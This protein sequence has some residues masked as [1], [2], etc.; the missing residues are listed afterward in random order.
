MSAEKK[1]T[2]STEVLIV[3]DST[4]QA[5]QLSHVLVQGGYNV[6]IAGNGAEALQA[7][8]ETRPD[9]IISDAV[10]PVMDGYTMCRII[11][12]DVHLREIP[13]ILLTSLSDPRDVINGIEAGVDHYLTKPYQADALLSKIEAVLS[14][15]PSREPDDTEGQFSVTVAGD[16]R[17][18]RSSKQRLLTLLLSTYESA[19]LRNKELI[20]A[21]AELE[22]ANKELEA[23]AYAVSHDLRAPLR[24][25]SGFSHALL[26]DYG[27]DLKGEARE[28]LDQITQ[29]S[30][31]MGELID[32]ILRLS[33]STRGEL[34]REEVNLSSLAERILGDMIKAEPDRRVAWKV[35]PNLTARC[36]VKL[37]EVVLTNLLGN[38]WKYT[39]HTSEP[40]IR[41]YSENRDGEKSFCV[42]DNGAGFDMKYTAKLFQPFQ[43]L[44][45]QDEFPGIGIG[46]A[47]V[48]R[49]I[50]RHGGTIRA[51]GAPGKGAAFS[52]SLALRDSS[53]KEKA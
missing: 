47:T 36:D 45:R 13:L 12:D 10:M 49:I 41:F 16:T 35:Q 19:V 5:T 4:T 28:F 38:A 30:T 24:A 25:L 29:A 1:G 42:S 39:A 8:R 43:R 34:F 31:K 52:F 6:R 15:A 37:M 7:V 33:R 48:Q 53:N 9:I 21:Q 23:F 46:L 40:T 51:T 3:E 26:E 20:E 27:A 11:K 17:I 44:H 32:G 18:V 14:S 50:H 2:T 22:A